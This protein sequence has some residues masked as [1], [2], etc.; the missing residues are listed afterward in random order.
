MNAED[1]PEAGPSSLLTTD[2]T[3]EL[4]QQNISDNLDKQTPMASGTPSTEG[5]D[6]AS[7]AT[8]LLNGEDAHESL[9]E[10]GGFN[11]QQPLTEVELGENGT[12]QLEVV[13]PEDTMADLGMHGELLDNSSDDMLV[14]SDGLNGQN[15]EQQGWL[16]LD[17]D[18]KR[19]KARILAIITEFVG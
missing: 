15:D 13:K 16:D 6:S 14:N 5:Q 9:A 19:I 11:E 10:E 3:D 2:S 12:I 8:V 18:M 1:G 4:E 17:C 7:S